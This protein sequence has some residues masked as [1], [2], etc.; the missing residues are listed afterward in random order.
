LLEGVIQDGDHWLASLPYALLAVITHQEHTV[1]VVKLVGDGVEI[2]EEPQGALELR[3]VP[4]P[5]LGRKLRKWY[6]QR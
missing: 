6:A 2:A 3:N 4:P 5:E 1:R